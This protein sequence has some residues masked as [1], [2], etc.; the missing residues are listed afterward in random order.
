MTKKINID[1]VADVADGIKDRI[2]EFKEALTALDCNVYFYG[3]ENP[4]YALF[5]KLRGVVCRILGEAEYLDYELEDLE[6]EIE[7]LREER[8]TKYRIEQERVRAER[9]RRQQD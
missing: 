7:Q 8:R 1:D 9:E 4:E 3:E 6:S 5:T 2:T